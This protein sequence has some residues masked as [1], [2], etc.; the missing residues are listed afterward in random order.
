MALRLKYGATMRRRPADAGG[1]AHV[2][3][4]FDVRP[5]RVPSSFAT[6]RS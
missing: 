3:E 5:S 2:M 6:M 4:G 1:D